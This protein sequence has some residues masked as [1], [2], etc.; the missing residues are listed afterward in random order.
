MIAGGELPD[1]DLPDTSFAVLGLL[2]FGARSGYDLLKLAETSIGFFWTPARSHVYS[3]LKRLSSL[4]LVAHERVEQ[5]D[6]PSK[7]VYSITT[8]G[9]SALRRWLEGPALEPD[10]VRSQFLLKVFFGALM[11]RDALVELVERR[12]DEAERTAA[13]LREIDARIDGEDR[14]L[15]P[16]LTLRHGLVRADGVVAWA[17]DTIRELSDR[18]ARR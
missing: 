5:T 13:Q 8:S 10:Q 17:E 4:G 9:R 6:R 12:R 7:R 18:G 11:D 15:F 1:P 14:W 16:R 2:T 3:E